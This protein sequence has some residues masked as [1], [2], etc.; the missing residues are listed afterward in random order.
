MV[1]AVGGERRHEERAKPASGEREGV[2]A[3]GLQQPPR[4]R[5]QHEPDPTGDGDP[6]PRRD[7]ALV[8][9]EAIEKADPDEQHEHADP[10]DRVGFGDQP[11]ERVLCRQP[12]DRGPR[13]IGR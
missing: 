4:D 8:A 10:D 1:E 13:A 2:G 12:I 5:E 9:C 3:P 7:P 11:H 6:E